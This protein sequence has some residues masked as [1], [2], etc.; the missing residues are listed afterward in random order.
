M[1]VAAG[2]AGLGLPATAAAA[3]STGADPAA[4]SV[5]GR[6]AGSAVDQAQQELWQSVRWAF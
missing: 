5:Q 4:S 6:A 3:G 2:A 1:P